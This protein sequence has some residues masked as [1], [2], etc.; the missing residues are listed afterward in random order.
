[1]ENAAP[2]PTPRL[3]T[4]Q[5]TAEL[6]SK[7]LPRSIEEAEAQARHLREMRRLDSLKHAAAIKRS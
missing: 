2:L 1:M 6:N 7:R 3:P 5:E 4:R